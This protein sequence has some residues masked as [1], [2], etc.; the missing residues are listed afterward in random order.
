MKLKF[1]CLLMLG[2]VGL[3]RSLATNPIDIANAP[4]PITAVESKTLTKA[5]TKAI[6]KL[7][8]KE[9]R[10]Q[11]RIAMVQKMMG[12]NMAKK[13]IDFQDPVNKWLWFAIFGFGI[14]IVLS[15]LVSAGGWGLWWLAYLAGI[16]GTVAFVIWLLKKFGDA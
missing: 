10:Q 12:K 3:Q 14:A 5:E 7:E 2:V 15:I 9:V 13:A 4:K 6:Q 16:F 1:L 8:R 11:K